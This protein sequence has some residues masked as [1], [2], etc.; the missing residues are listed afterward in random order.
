MLQLLELFNHLKY[1]QAAFEVNILKSFNF[2][3]K[4][5]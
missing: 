1:G 5:V 2:D 4:L 3:I